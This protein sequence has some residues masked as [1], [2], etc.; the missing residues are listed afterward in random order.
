MSTAHET[1]AKH[2]RKNDPEGLKQRIFASALAE[3]SEAG[4]KGARLERIAE[5]ADTTKRMVVYHFKNKESLYI[6]VL[7]Y[8]YAHIR[9]DE[10]AL[11]LATLPPQAA[12]QRLIEANFDYHV[13]HPAFIR[14]VS[15]EN[16]QRGQYA[17]QSEKLKLLNASALQTLE[18]ILQRGKQQG[19]FSPDMNARDV[20]R[21]IS[22]L[23]FH[24]AANQYTFDTLFEG[25]RTA[26]EKLAYYRQMTVDVVMRYL[27]CK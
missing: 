9:Q 26:E 25:N 10:M 18:D 8:A 6:A 20:H 16:M 2:P 22:A 19:L 23:C 11:N 3:F 17:R 21:I 5:Q 1:S 24:H 13:A 14:L 27:Q 15:L 12:M 4:L 7:E